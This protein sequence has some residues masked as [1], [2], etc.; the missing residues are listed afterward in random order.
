MTIMDTEKDTYQNPRRKIKEKGIKT[1]LFLTAIS[2]IIVIFSI[3]F[4]LFREGY[5]IFEKAGLWNFLSGTRWFPDGNPPLFGTFSLIVGTL[6][7]T[8]GAMIISIP[9]S[10]GSAIFISEI[11]PPWL[12][13][14][15]KPAVELL[16]GI[17]SVVY[18]FFGL[19]VLVPLIADVFG[20]P[21]GLSW[22]AG[23]IILGI[24]AIP[25]ITS[26]A[27]DAINSVPKEFKEGSL[28]MGATK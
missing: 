23:S 25:T 27:E 1:I 9:L 13:N 3:I 20:V 24:M 7:V 19:I 2:A 17:P 4:F 14:F 10:I 16:A 6:L 21:T 15:I 28:A 18:G 22:L 8:L 26:I 11:A 12:R 5:P